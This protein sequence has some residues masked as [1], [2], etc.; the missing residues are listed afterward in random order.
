MSINDLLAFAVGVRF[1]VESIAMIVIDRKLAR[2][3]GLAIGEEWLA[4]E[5][6]RHAEDTGAPVCWTEYY[7]HRE[8]AGVGRLL[9]RH[10]GPIFPLIEDLFGQSVSEVHQEIAAALVSP[11]LAEGLQ[12]E[13]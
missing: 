11:A 4:I 2:R 3:T 8:F 12:V 7:I 9:S 10:S 13:T 5:G 1:A 6:F